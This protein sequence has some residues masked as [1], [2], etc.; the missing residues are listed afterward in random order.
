MLW[1]L[2][3]FIVG[4]FTTEGSPW[5]LPLLQ[6]N[7]SDKKR[8]FL[9][10]LNHPL[11]K[12]SM[13]CMKKPASSNLWQVPPGCCMTFETKEHQTE[14]SVVFGASSNIFPGSHWP[15]VNYLLCLEEATFRLLCPVLGSPFQKRYG[16]PRGCTVEGH[17]DDK[18]PGA[19]PIWGK[20]WVCS[21]W[22]IWVYSVW[23][24]EDW[25]GIW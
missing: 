14:M 10:Y 11:Q 1:L 20:A 2:P 6:N 7:S 18:H 12:D 16:S 15:S 9:C 23:G 5:K 21:P 25:E 3:R 24:K 4:E 19:S 17:K 8:S 22:G 13:A